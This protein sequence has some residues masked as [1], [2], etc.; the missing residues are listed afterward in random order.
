MVVNKILLLA[1]IANLFL[2]N[3]YGQVGIGTTVVNNSS[4]LDITSTTKGLLP[5]RMSTTNRNAISNPAD[6]LLVYDITTDS[7]WYSNAGKWIELAPLN[8]VAYKIPADRIDPTG[9][10]AD[11]FGFAVSMGGVGTTCLVGAPGAN[12]GTGECFRLTASSNNLWNFSSVSVAGLLAG[13]GF[14]YAV[15]MDRFNSTLDGIIGAPFDDSSTVNDM[16]CA[17]F[18]NNNLS[19]NKVYASA[20]HRTANARFGR[21]VD[22]AGNTN[23]DK[24]FAIVGAPGAN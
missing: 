14:G 6:G 24:G 9:N 15:A 22:I 11:K 21:S 12:S 13:D 19:I 3:S 17:Y 20:T 16:G 10:A 8:N 18:I 5:P 23:A 2:I 4:M 7:Y 1:V